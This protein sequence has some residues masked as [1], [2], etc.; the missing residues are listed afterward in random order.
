[1]RNAW[2]ISVNMG[3]GHQRTAFPLRNLTPNRKIINANDYP[4]IPKKDRIFWGTTRKGY[5][6][7]SKLKRLPVLGKSIFFIFD[8]FQKILSF[9]PKRDL[10]KPNSQLKQTF[11]LIKKGWGRHLIEKLKQ[12]PLPLVSTFFTPAFM[13]EFFNYPSAATGED[14]R[15]F[16]D[17]PSV[18]RGRK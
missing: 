6:L 18:A 15:K 17:Y 9:Y 11:S 10:S 14:E 16:I 4:G 8:Q 13:A 12:K 5:E 3:Y 2:L 1:M 7:I